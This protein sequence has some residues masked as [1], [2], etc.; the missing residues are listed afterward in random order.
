MVTNYHCFNP[1]PVFGG[2][3]SIMNY[4]WKK[5]EL[6]VIISK[7]KQYQLVV[8]SNEGLAA[9]SLLSFHIKNIKDYDIEYIVSK[10][11]FEAI[12]SPIKNNS[13]HHRMMIFLNKLELGYQKY[14]VSGNI[15]NENYKGNILF[16]MM[17]IL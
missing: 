2:L 16:P 5:E 9:A 3:L 4:Q 6:C 14:Q 13:F 17:E 8:S 10:T 12:I 7:I 11:K 1:W 15:I